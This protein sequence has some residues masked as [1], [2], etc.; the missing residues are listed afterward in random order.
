VGEVSVQPGP[1]FA[2]ATHFRIIV[3]GRGGH[4][5]APHETV[6]PIVTAAHVITALQTVVSRNINAD[7][8]AVVSIG[9]I[10]G[11]KRGN[12]IPNEVMMTGTIR[13]YD[14]EVL[15][16][17]LQRMGDIIAG[18]AAAHGAESQFD[19]STLGACVNATRE[20]DLVRTVAAGL[21][22][23]SRVRTGRTNGADDMAYFLNE[24]PGAYFML[25]AQPRHVERFYPHHHPK[26]DIDEAAIPIGIELGLRI[27]GEASGSKL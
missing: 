7:Q 3:R 23:E 18:T 2:A 11:G 4:A 9:R 10:E 27:V 8:S 21:L 13:T 24:A 19:C 16:K 17:I 22:G 26:F 1:V 15:Q 25:G 14:E 5:A 20:A 12:I 6:D